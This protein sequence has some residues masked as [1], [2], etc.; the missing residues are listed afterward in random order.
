MTVLALWSMM[1]TVE[2]CRRTHI[3]TKNPVDALTMYERRFVEIKK[4]LP[5]T[6]TVGYVGDEI[7]D[8]GTRHYYRTQYSLAPVVVDR[9]AGHELVIG[10]FRE[11]VHTRIVAAAPGLTLLQDFG[12]GVML[13]KN[14]AWLQEARHARPETNADASGK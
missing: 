6:G 11:D 2:S 9:T 8:E 14:D 10:N 4:R 12:G 7:G 3:L 5:D 13:F 1:S